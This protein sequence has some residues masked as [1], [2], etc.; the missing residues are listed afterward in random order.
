MLNVISTFSGAGA[1]DYGFRSTGQFQTTAF[2]ELEPAF[3]KTILAN[4]AE[5]LLCNGEVIT[6]DVT[7]CISA[8]SLRHLS[9]MRPS[10]LIGGPPCQS[11]SSIGKQRGRA[12][13][14]GTLIFRFAELASL[15]PVEFFV[16][17]NVPGLA[18]IEAGAVLRDLL[19]AFEVG[20]FQVHHRVLCAADY[21]AA[22]TRR[23]LVIA[24]FR[25]AAEFQF[26]A[27]THHDPTTL[28]PAAARRWVTVRQALEGLPAPAAEGEHRL[29][30]HVT[31]RHAATVVERFRTVPQGTW[32]TVRKRA[33]LAEDRPSP[34]LIAGNKCGTRSHI[35]PTEPRELTNRESAR[36]Q[37][38]PDQYRFVGTRAEVGI[39]IANAVPVALGA[40]VARQVARCLESRLPSHREPIRD[41]SQA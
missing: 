20:G 22:T 17:E 27:A 29:G 26:P 24:G 9:A 34:S 23:R 4:Q 5:G 21:G 32:D 2:I 36:L 28:T 7:D 8:K 31:I 38:F 3:C 12:D 14:R 6:T 16:M 11:F 33:R 25:P 41:N 18:T 10:G 15:L 40:A 1:L 35:H 30:D 39:Q 19:R 37:G 13:P